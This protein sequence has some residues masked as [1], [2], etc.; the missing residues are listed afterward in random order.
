MVRGGRLIVVVGGSR[1]PPIV[2][3]LLG[4]RGSDVSL[5]L[6]VGGWWR[7]GWITASERRTSTRFSVPRLIG[8]SASRLG[9]SGA[10]WPEKI[11]RDVT[12]L[13]HF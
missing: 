5:L 7:W 9:C 4:G 1:G 6:V 11:K 2:T 10:L 3:P 13:L 8:A 12:M